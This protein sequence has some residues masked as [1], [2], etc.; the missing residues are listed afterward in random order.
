MTANA[1][2]AAAELAT[3][4]SADLWAYRDGTLVGRGRVLPMDDDLDAD[5]HTLSITGK[6]YEAI[7]ERRFLDPGDTLTFLNVDQ[8]Q[9]LWLL[10]NGS[11]SKSGGALGITQ[12]A[13]GFTAGTG[14]TGVLRTRTYQIDQEIGRLA[15][16]LAE[17]QNGFDFEIDALRRLQVYYPQRGVSQG[18]VLVYGSN[19]VKAKRSYNWAAAANTVAV[20]GASGTTRATA[21]SGTIGTDPRGRIEARQALPSVTEN[22]TLTARASSLLTERSRASYGWL[23]E[24]KRGAWGGFGHVDVGDTVTLR[25]RSL[26]RLNVNAPC[27]VHEIR[28]KIGPSGEEDV[29]MKLEQ[30]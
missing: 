3:E 24:L 5:R 15:R 18:A 20:T 30:L 13:N 28:V 27:R 10:L 2:Q 19:V 26:P 25:V 17:V 21:T 11:Q 22:A 7:F 29:S 8:A 14:S 4:W 9:I 12:G 23:I 1:R 16:Q 6:G